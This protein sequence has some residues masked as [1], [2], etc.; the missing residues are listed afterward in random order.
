MT[1]HLEVRGIA[2][3]VLCCVDLAERVT[4][5]SSASVCVPRREDRPEPLPIAASIPAAPAAKL[6]SSCMIYSRALQVRL[7]QERH[8]RDSGH[9]GI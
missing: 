8:V 6:S 9:K 7:K 4:L 5:A 3:P 2:E 1:E